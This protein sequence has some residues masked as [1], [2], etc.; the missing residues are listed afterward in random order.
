MRWQRGHRSRHVED[1]R[2]SGGGFGGRLGGGR[3]QLGCGGLLVVLVLSVVFQTDFFS[4]LGPALST[5]DQTAPNSRRAP[6]VDVEG[7]KVDFVHWLMDDIQTVWDQQYPAIAGRSYE[8][9][10]LVLF[11]GAINSGCGFASSA[12]GPFYCPADRKAY[13][14]LGFF[15]D[16]SR[17]FGAPGDFARA[18]VVAH[19][20][21]HHIQTILGISDQV[22]QSQAR[23]PRQANQIQVRMELQADCLAGV[24]GHSAAQRG[25]LERGDVEE[26]LR[27]AAA[28]GDDRIQRMSGEGYINP[29]AFTHGSS[30]QR[31][32]WFRRG[33]D[34]GDPDACDTFG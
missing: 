7:E 33:L 16:L 32:R 10:R 3:M 6:G 21:G 17:R 27:A 1:R 22:R 25:R 4:L 12:T 8:Y 34:S 28:I 14:D 19:E 26:G 29:E 9:A 15:D 31:V 23:N 30:E 13:I 18:Y 24:W 5:Q 2:Q 20:I 11:R